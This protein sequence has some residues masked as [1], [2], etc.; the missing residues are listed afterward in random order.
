M[1]QRSKQA[2][3]TQARTGGSICLPA[4]LS[5]LTLL[6]LLLLIGLRPVR[7]QADAAAPRYLIVGDSRV[8]GIGETDG[9]EKIGTLTNQA[10]YGSGVGGIYYN[11]ERDAVA[12]GIIGARFDWMYDRD[13]ARLNPSFR[14]DVKAHCAKRTTV[15][16]LMGANDYYLV[17]TQAGAERIAGC[18]VKVAKKIRSISRCRRVVTCGTFDASDVPNSTWTMEAYNAAMALLRS[19]QESAVT[20]L[21]STRYKYINTNKLYKRFVFHNGLHLTK[22]SSALLFKWLRKNR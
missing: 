16:L 21:N 17:D 15:F 11:A 3:M 10:S 2:E 13:K 8:V 22:E 14:A 9:F 4:L 7:A 6:S 19:A 1:N 20:A 5:L 18:Y 12:M